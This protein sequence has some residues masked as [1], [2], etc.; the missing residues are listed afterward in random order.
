MHALSVQVMACCGNRQ[1]FILF[2][3]ST[4]LRTVTN[5]VQVFC[6][7]YITNKY[8]LYQFKCFQESAFKMEILTLKYF[9]TFLKYTNILTKYTVGGGH[10]SLLEGEVFWGFRHLFRN[11]DPDPLFEV[12]GN[13]AISFISSKTRLGISIVAVVA[14]K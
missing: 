14:L 12:S 1:S 3:L 13:F 4:V 5:D 6:H 7:V 11:K 2:G 10:V 8:M 9:N